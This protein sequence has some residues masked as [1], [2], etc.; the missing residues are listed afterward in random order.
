[1]SRFDM[2]SGESEPVSRLDR[3]FDGLIPNDFVIS[4]RFR[5]DYSVSVIILI[6]KVIN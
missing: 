1:M 5:V 6:K 2:Q 3:N 4:A